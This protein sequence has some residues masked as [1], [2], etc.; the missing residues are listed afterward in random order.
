VRASNKPAAPNPAKAS[1][2]HG[3]HHRRGVGEPGV[4]DSKGVATPEHFNFTGDIVG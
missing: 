3:G 2:L 1:Q 4:L